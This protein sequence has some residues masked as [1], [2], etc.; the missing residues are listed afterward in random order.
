MPTF[1]DASESD[2]RQR[3]LG[4][5][6]FMAVVFAF[7]GARQLQL[8]VVKYEEL[9]QAAQSNYTVD[10][11]IVAD[12]GTI[13]DR[14]GRVLAS[15]RPTFDVYLTPR[16]I[17][18]PKHFIERL[19]EILQFDTLDRLELEDIIQSK[20]KRTRYKKRKL[21]TDVSRAQVAQL[22]A[23][24]ARQG[25]V[26]LEVSYQRVYPQG[27]VGAHFQNKVGA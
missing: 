8:Q 19:S 17:R 22:E 26:S 13:F 6:L 10:H 23:L 25:G 27:E 20:Q 16:L 11:V 24:A 15:N 4:V 3:L 18:Q 1:I 5:V 7:F 2:Q 14:H 12:R 21:A 9:S